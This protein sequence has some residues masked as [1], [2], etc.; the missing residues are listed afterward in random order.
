MKKLFLLSIIAVFAIGSMNAQGQFRAGING[1]IPVGD[2][3]DF[4]TF[5]IAVDLGY[6]F[7]ISDDFDAGIETG[8]TNFFGKDGF[9]GFSFI[10]ITA[11]G[12]LDVSEE[13]SLEAGAGYAVSLESNG[14]G[15]FYWKFQAAYALDEDSDIGLS[16]RSVSGGNGFSLDAIMLGYRRNL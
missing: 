13:I 10:P 3:A 8:Y 4:S 12:N 5:A 9:D 16:Y 7:E 14:G 1:G 11:V 15:D 6:L 2:F